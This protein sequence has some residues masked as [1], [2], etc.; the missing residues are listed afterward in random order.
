MILTS[1]RVSNLYSKIYSRW[2]IAW[3]NGISSRDT[4]ANS[5]L[6]LFVAEYSILLYLFVDV[7]YYS[8]HVWQVHITHTLRK[9]SSFVWERSRFYAFNSTCCKQWRLAASHA[10]ISVNLQIDIRDIYLHSHASSK[11]FIYNSIIRDIVQNFDSIY[12]WPINAVTVVG[13]TGS[14]KSTITV[15]H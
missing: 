2:Y 6:H 14:K 5:M 7:E 8:V 13:S 11:T 3:H 10:S 15:S 4:R 12:P 9:R 1:L